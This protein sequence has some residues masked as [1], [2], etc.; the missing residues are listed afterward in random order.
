M[1]SPLIRDRTGTEI[2]ASWDLVYSLY[3]V[4]FPLDKAKYNILQSQRSPEF[5]G[6]QIE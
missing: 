1:P 4:M 6:T 3:Q 5:S 2:Q